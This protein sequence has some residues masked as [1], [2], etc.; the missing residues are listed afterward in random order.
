MLVCSAALAATVTR[1][2]AAIAAPLVSVFPIAGQQ[3]ASPQTQIAFRG[4]PA[5][6]LGVIIVTGSVSGPHAGTIEADSD[7]NGGSFLPA[8]PFKPGEIVTVRTSLNI[9]LASGGSFHFTIA[10][11]RPGSPVPL[12]GLAVLRSPRR[13]ALPLAQ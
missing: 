11:R 12:A 5:S 8:N 7:G 9:V 4:E 6:R 13:L 1:G 3:V 2:E 10:D